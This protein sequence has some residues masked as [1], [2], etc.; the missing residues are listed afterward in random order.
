MVTAHASMAWL[1]PRQLSPSCDFLHRSYLVFSWELRRP[2][3]DAQGAR[4]PGA[5]TT[6]MFAGEWDVCA[7][8]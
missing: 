7:R 1:D 8:W 6:F 2:D 5:L 3:A 4:Q